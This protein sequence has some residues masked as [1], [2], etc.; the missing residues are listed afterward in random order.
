M[1]FSVVEWN[2]N[3]HKGKVGRECTKA[4]YNSIISEVTRPD[5]IILNEYKEEKNLDKDFEKILARDFYF[6]S[7]NDILIG[8]DNK[9]WKKL[10]VLGYDFEGMSLEFAWDN[11]SLK[12]NLYPDLY[13]VKGILK[14]NM[15]VIIVGIRIKVSNVN[16]NKMASEEKVKDYQNRWDQ[17]HF[18]FNIIDNI[19]KKIL[20]EMKDDARIPIILAGDFNNSRYF[21]DMNDLGGAVQKKYKGLLTESYNL[22]LIKKEFY[23]H[24]FEYF[25][26]T[27]FGDVDTVYSNKLRIPCKLD[28]IFVKN[29]NVTSV[30]Y[31]SKKYQSDHRMLIAVVG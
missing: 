14:N 18:A 11:S 21:G 1:N 20:Q 29:L 19:E 28:H 5:V 10:K 8:L 24:G 31:S 27:P 16:Y 3:G 30:K 25:Y 23:N 7:A 17:L 6:K 13:A 12:Y 2:V 9:K 4:F 26:S 15:P 22:Q